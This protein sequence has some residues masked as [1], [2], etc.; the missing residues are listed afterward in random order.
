M[1][2][3]ENLSVAYGQSNVIPDMSFS[4]APD[5][6]PVQGRLYDFS[7]IEALTEAAIAMPSGT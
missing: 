5:A 1:I 7:S 3:I 4:A 6:P 2:S